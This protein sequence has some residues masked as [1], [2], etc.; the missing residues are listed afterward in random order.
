MNRM[1]IRLKRNGRKTIG[2]LTGLCNSHYTY[3][4]FRSLHRSALSGNM[5]LIT[6]LGGSYDSTHGYPLEYQN[7]ILFYL[8]SP[9]N[10]DGVILLPSVLYSYSRKERYQGI[11]EQLGKMPLL[12]LSEPVEGHPGIFVDNT[13]GTRE[14][15]CHLHRSHGMKR[16]AFISGPADSTESM[17][18]QKGFM[19]GHTDCGLKHD[20]RYLLKGNFWLTGGKSAIETLEQ[21][22]HPWPEAFICA[23]DYTAYGV[24]EELNKRGINVPGDIAVTGFDNI[25][26]SRYAI[27]PLTSISQ[28]LEEMAKLAIDYILVMI[29]GEKVPEKT[30]LPTRN[31]YR[32]TTGCRPGEIDKTGA[33]DTKVLFGDGDT[34]RKAD[35]WLARL[36]SEG[37]A[38]QEEAFANLLYEYIK[39]GNDPEPWGDWLDQL[40]GHPCFQGDGGSCR[41]G[42][43]RLHLAQAGEHKQ[44]I[45]VARKEAL[46]GLQAQAI[47]RIIGVYTLD[48]L[49]ER[50]HK[51]LPALGFGIFFLLLHTSP[52]EHDLKDEWTLPPKAR[53]LCGYADGQKLKPSAKNT[54]FK[55]SRLLPDSIEFPDRPLSL[56]VVASS[57][58]NTHYGYI[59]MEG[60]IDD[61]QIYN[62]MEKQIS[63]AYRGTLVFAEK[64]VKTRQLEEMSTHDPLTGLYNRRGFLLVSEKYQDLAQRQKNGF[65]LFFGDMDGLKGINDTW[66]HEAGDKAIA[67]CA[68][69]LKRTFRKSDILARIGG[70]EFTI[71]T[72]HSGFI[73]RE[74]IE[75][76]LHSILD[77]INRTSGQPWK[78]AISFGCVLST[79]YPGLEFCEL[80]AK[81]DE[82]LYLQ[83][84]AR[85][86]TC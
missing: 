39:R 1:G 85:K 84:K 70:D 37:F 43:L 81:A 58:L 19:M 27:P 61:A 55:T 21:S 40:A 74:R 67:L 51:E 42:V 16:L 72:V 30:I 8:P 12:T 62:T 9:E 79:D 49:V 83:K 31:H 3:T 59:I 46:S 10:M 23:N 54:V 5:N 33:P 52:F 20:S 56:V 47:Q 15:V 29:N 82:G 36:G 7:N 60:S 35:D 28:P 34:G 69:A 6:L 78:I 13:I 66:G 57:F 80:M 26:T 50:L 17:E 44:G 48:D 77:E 4:L 22:G 71:L 63:T 41:Y 68:H 11:I 24:M 18:R 32:R 75:E 45:K 64:E 86:R 73:D 65:L 14:M 2:L 76:R 38:R 53:Y 25:E